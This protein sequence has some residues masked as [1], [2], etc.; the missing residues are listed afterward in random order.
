MKNVESQLEKQQKAI[1]A[2][3]NDQKATL[4]SNASGSSLAS[5][6]YRIR[7]IIGK[8]SIWRLALKMYL[9]RFLI[10]SF[11]C[12]TCVER[13]P[14]RPCL[15]PKWRTFNLAIF[16][17]FAK[18]KP[19]PN[20]PRIWY[21]RRVYGQSC[22]LNKINAEQK[23]KEKRLCTKWRNLPLVRVLLENRK[24][25]ISVS[26]C[27]RHTWPYCNNSKCYSLR[28]TFREI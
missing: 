4:S 25:L 17:S 9:A 13:N 6:I 14:C 26:H 28:Q 19:P 11:E 7:G 15:Q 3:S 1:T 5:P 21:Y 8:L 23:E 2:V 12:C 16:T 20:I 27:F 10:S 24:I 18:L 22:C